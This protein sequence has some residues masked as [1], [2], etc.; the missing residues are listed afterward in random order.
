[1]VTKCFF[2]EN[3]A[4]LMIITTLGGVITVRLSATTPINVRMILLLPVGTVGI[5]TALMSVFSRIV[6]R[7]HTSVV[8]AVLLVSRSPKDIARSTI[9]AQPT[10]SNKT[11]SKVPFLI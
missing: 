7:V 6:T 5:T 10:K 1:M 11:S 4:E 3:H 8:T 9:S 2:V